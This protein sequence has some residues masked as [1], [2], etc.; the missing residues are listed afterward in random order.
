MSTERID[1]NATPDALKKMANLIL[2]GIRFQEIA[3]AETLR[4]C[5]QAW[6][7]ERSDAATLREQVKERGRVALANLDRSQDMEGKLAQAEERIRLLERWSK[8]AEETLVYAATIL[9]PFADKEGGPAKIA[10]DECE[11]RF[12]E[13]AQMPDSPAA[14]SEEKP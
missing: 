5:A 13:Y 1:T 4:L 12:V 6:E 8:R 9:G 11:S 10:M 3:I 7:Q 2:R 14:A